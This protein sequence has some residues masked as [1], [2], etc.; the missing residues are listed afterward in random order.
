MIG[1]GSESCLPREKIGGGSESCLP[2]ETTRRRRKL[3]AGRKGE[4]GS[5]ELESELGEGSL[6]SLRRERLGEAGLSQCWRA[7]QDQD[8]CGS[9]EQVGIASPL[10]A[11]HSEGPTQAPICRDDL[12]PE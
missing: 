7:E 3:S 9:A 10:T 2:R 12:Q 5:T 6:A 1:G 8:V 4:S 11:G